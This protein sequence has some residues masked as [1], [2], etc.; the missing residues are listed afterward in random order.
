MDITSIVAELREQRDRL[1]AAISALERT[2]GATA[3]T[4]TGHT[5]KRHM[6]AEARARIS[7]GLKKRWAAAHK[8]GKSTLAK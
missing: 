4:R 6:S 5:S 2:N 8:E 7:A 3:T 1:D